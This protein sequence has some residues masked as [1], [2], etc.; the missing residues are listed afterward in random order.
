MTPFFSIIIPVYNVAPYLRECLDSV[1]AQ[2]FTDWEAI[3][4][5][6]G[7]TDGSGMIIDEYATNDKRI[8]AQHQV[9]MGVSSA[10]NRGLDFVLGKW[11]LFLDSDDFWKCNFLEKIYAKILSQVDLDIVCVS[12]I[13]EADCNGRIQGCCGRV[14]P[15]NILSG[16][17][18]LRKID[19]EY[20]DLGWHS[21]DKVYRRELIK[22]SNILFAQDVYSG[23]DALFVY[24]LLVRAKKVM[25]CDDIFA[26]V[27]RIHLNSA[28]QKFSY[29][30]WISQLTRFVILFDT[31]CQDR[32]YQSLLTVLRR[33]VF[34]VVRIGCGSEFR[35]ECIE[36]LI[37]SVQFHLKV[38]P[39][40]VHYG[41]LK[42]RLIGLVL[43]FSPLRVQSYILRLMK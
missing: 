37:N 35:K 16:N 11:I 13:L 38:L 43:F 29:R 17:Q 4:V 36:Y 42:T 7:S 33:D 15:A 34:C 30:M 40:L 22:E 18:I 24:L 10:R 23:E 9:N 8:I 25:I 28:T 1:L 41:T 12:P 3:C 32:K 6:D 20:L 19:S 14:L 2:T 39:F 5:D 31:W 21:V 27:R 26:Y